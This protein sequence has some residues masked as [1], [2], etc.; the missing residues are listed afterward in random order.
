MYYR[1]A[2]MCED[3]RTGPRHVFGIIDEKSG[4]HLIPNKESL[5]E[6]TNIVQNNSELKRLSNWQLLFTFPMLQ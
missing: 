3:M 5:C 2:G 6:C 4:F 1:A